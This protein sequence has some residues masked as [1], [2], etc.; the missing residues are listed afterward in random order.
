M[1]ILKDII[2]KISAIANIND[3]CIPHDMQI[4][5]FNIVQ[6]CILFFKLDK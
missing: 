2:Y 4:I 5:G 6:S 3:A 1:S